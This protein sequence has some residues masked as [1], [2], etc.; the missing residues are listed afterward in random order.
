[1]GYLDETINAAVSLRK[2]FESIGTDIANDLYSIIVGQFNGT[3]YGLDYR[4]KS[5]ESL[6]RKIQG[7]MTE[8]FIDENGKK[9]TTHKTAEEVSKGFM[10]H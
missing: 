8:T 7:D 10:I 4:L 9:V 1:M 5:I 3:M 2:N 6:A